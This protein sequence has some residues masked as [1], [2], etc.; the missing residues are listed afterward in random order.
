MSKA[1]MQALNRLNLHYRSSIV[2]LAI[3]FTNFGL[4]SANLPMAQLFDVQSELYFHLISHD[5]EAR[6]L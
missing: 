1:L 4:E 5:N 2:V 3:S 6:R